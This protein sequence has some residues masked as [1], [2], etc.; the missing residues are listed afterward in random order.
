MQREPL[1]SLERIKIVDNGESLIALKKVC[2]AILID[3]EPSR[4]K[5]ERTLFA[6]KSVARMLSQAYEQLPEGITFKVR[7][8]WRPQEVQ[9]R[10]YNQALNRMK[11]THRSWSN[12]QVRRELNKWISPPDAKTPPWHTTGGAIDL[13]L[14]NAKGRSLPMQSRAETLPPHI[15]RN[16]RKL[17]I[18]MGDASFTN[19]EFEWWH[20][21]YGDTGWALR[22][23]RKTA[24]YGAV[25]SPL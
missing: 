15:Q 23:G 6:R 12:A 2:P 25:E 4:V 24:L 11:R 3:L 20:F 5:R 10:Y 14:C 16:R 17:R 13:T 8:A 7:D 1:R 21:S 22:S 9:A 19:Y 18:I